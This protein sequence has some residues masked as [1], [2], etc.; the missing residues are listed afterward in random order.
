MTSKLQIAFLRSLPGRPEKKKPKDEFLGHYCEECG[1][2]LSAH[3]EEGPAEEAP[4][5]DEKTK[6]A[7]FAKAL[8][9]KHQ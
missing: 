9:E 8:K 3:Q 5:I 6:S 4:P 2:E 1:G 7:L